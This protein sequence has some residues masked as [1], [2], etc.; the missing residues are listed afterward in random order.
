MVALGDR[1]PALAP[2]AWVAPS[3]VVVGDVDVFDGVRIF[4]G[5]VLRG[6]LNAIRVGAFS[7]VGPRAVLHAAAS[8]PTG[9][10]AATDVGRNVTIG[11]GALLRSATV[12]DES[13]IGEG[14]ILLEGS[15]VEE[16]AALAP[17]ALLPP[18]RRVPAGELW[19]GRPARFVRALTKDEKMDLPFVAD[20]ADAPAAAYAA[21]LLPQPE[22]WEEAEE[23]RA[24]L[25]KDSALAEAADLGSPNT[26]E[27][28]PPA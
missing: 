21:E 8:A 11:A 6:D 4:P 18:G 17:G 27:F 25:A 24:K 16:H 20:Q 23:L 3:A 2:D 7:V 5:A 10:P 19:A 1:V 9:L 15:L 26:P 13:T 12:R 22:A 14:A 28:H